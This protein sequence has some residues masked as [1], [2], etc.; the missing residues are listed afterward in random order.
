MGTSTLDWYIPKQHA[1]ITDD[2]K[3]L[4]CPANLTFGD[5][6][7]ETDADPLE[8]GEWTYFELDTRNIYGSLTVSMTVLDRK[9]VV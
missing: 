9:S 6:F 7:G 8:P 3:I 1:T 4:P 5:D 2:E